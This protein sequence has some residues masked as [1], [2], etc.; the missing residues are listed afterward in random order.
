MWSLNVVKVSIITQRISA[1]ISCDTK[2]IN[3]NQLRAKQISFGIKMLKRYISG[4][5]SFAPLTVFNWTP[6]L[7]WASRSADT[8]NREND[9]DD[10]F[11]LYFCI[12]SDEEEQLCSTQL[13]LLYSM[14][15]YHVLTDI[16]VK[17]LSCFVHF[18]CVFGYKQCFL[19]KML[20][21]IRQRVIFCRRVA[22]LRLLVLNPGASEP[23]KSV[24]CPGFKH[25]ALQKCP[26][27]GDRMSAS[28][29]G[30]K[31]Q[32]QTDVLGGQWEESREPGSGGK[33]VIQM[34]NSIKNTPLQVIHYLL[35]YIC[36]YVYPPLL[37]CLTEVWFGE[38]SPPSAGPGPAEGPRPPAVM[39]G[40]TR[41]KLTDLTQ[42]SRGKQPNLFFKKWKS[43]L[44]AG[45]SCRWVSSLFSL[46]FV[47]CGRL[48]VNHLS[49]D[50]WMYPDVSLH[51]PR[52]QC[53]FKSHH[54]L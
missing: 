8:R 4:S 36:M 16:Y 43:F 40:N 24:K 53:F 6:L 18:L 45:I 41:V 1:E 33:S 14:L 30:E 22:S 17:L 42:H 25:H 50:S 7:R 51:C 37:H 15:Y 3:P 39:T 12:R 47:S 29:S 35:S 48:W 49:C 46:L 32:L 10:S 2:I 27:A 44:N 5:F 26:W 31:V 9:E 23:K 19:N 13:C 28:L 38:K 54:S 21:F 52:K 20:T 11:Q 34:F